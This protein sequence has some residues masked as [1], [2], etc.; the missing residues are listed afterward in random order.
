MLPHQPYICNREDYQKYR[1]KVKQPLVKGKK[2]ENY[3]PYLQWWKRNTDSVEISEEENLRCKAAYCGLVSKLDNMI[4]EII[5]CLKNN[6]LF[7]DTIIIYTSDH[8][9]QLGEHGLWWK[10]TFYEDS[11]KVPTIITFP[12]RLKSNIKLDKVINHY[13]VTATM[14]DLV[15]APCLPRS[16]GKSFKKLLEENDYY[17]ED[18]AISEYCMD[19]SDFSNISGNLGGRDI[20][21]KSGGVQ[22]KMI[23]RGE[24]KLVFYAGYKAQFF[25]LKEDPNE[26]FDRIE[27]N[28]CK[29]I[30]EFL[31]NEIQIDWNPKSIHKRM[32]ELKKDQILQH[33]WA[34]LT[35]PEDILRWELDPINDSS[36]LEKIN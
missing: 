18:L 5:T 13:D 23:R 14:L 29:E 36:K 9:D 30:R 33:E 19:D 15:E 16:K 35:D 4:G 2:I 21:A 26:L 22:N 1:E 11:V 25:N 12:K 3:H 8:G 7:D 34:K 31:L 32:I 10:Q 27:D 20:H 6:K 17:W 28:R 24:W